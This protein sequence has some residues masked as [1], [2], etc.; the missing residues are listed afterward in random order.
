[1]WPQF[2]YFFSQTIKLFTVWFERAAGVVDVGKLR[3]FADTHLPSLPDLDDFISQN[4]K[5]LRVVAEFKGVSGQG[6]RKWHGCSSHRPFR[7]DG[8]CCS[9]PVL[10]FFPLHEF[11]V[12][13]WAQSGHF[14]L[15]LPIVA[16]VSWAGRV[17]RVVSVNC[18][19]I[20][21]WIMVFLVYL[22]MNALAVS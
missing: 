3:L 8:R 20:F 21:S 15:V 17:T 19:M 16:V 12:M 14:D 13:S 4:D 18:W 11:R 1:M 10:T 22:R 9:H 5:G 2:F 6:T 7:W